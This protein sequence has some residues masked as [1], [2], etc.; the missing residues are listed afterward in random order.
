MAEGTASD[1]ARLLAA[2]GMRRA[3]GMSDGRRFDS[4]V[5]FLEK[6]GDVSGMRH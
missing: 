6:H 4:I 3:S 2:A 1:P 5:I